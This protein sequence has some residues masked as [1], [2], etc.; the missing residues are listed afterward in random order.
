[1]C[2]AASGALTNVEIG[3]RCL[4]EETDGRKYTESVFWGTIWVGMRDFGVLRRAIDAE[5][6]DLAIWTIPGA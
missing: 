1:M 6:Q 3:G 4:F 5:L 2:L